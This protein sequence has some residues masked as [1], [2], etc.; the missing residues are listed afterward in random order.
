M[1]QKTLISRYTPFYF[2]ILTLNGRVP[3][4]AASLC[5]M[6]LLYGAGTLVALGTGALMEAMHLHLFHGVIG[7]F[8]VGSFFLLNAFERTCDLATSLSYL[9]PGDD[10]AKFLSRNFFR[11][12]RSKWQI[13]V[14][15]ACAL[16]S[17]AWFQF[18]VG[19]LIP[20]MS[21]FL[22]YARIIAMIC[23]FFLFPG[24]WL[25]ATSACFVVAMS[26][27]CSS[28]L[29]PVL[30]GATPSLEKLAAWIGT[31]AIYFTVEGIFFIIV[32]SIPHYPKEYPFSAATLGIL[33]VA[34]VLF[35]LYLIYP[36]YTLYRMIRNE[37]YRQMD[38]VGREMTKL[39]EQ[40]LKKITPSA[41]TQFGQLLQLMRQSPRY[42]SFYGGV[43]RSI[44][45]MLLWLPFLIIRPQ[46]IL[47]A[48]IGALKKLFQLP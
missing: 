28:R 25:A 5:W 4:L 22:L 31:M 44:V 2:R 19:K 34:I 20:H 36:Q 3:S 38:L 35:M 46:E 40:T 29:F 8:G 45:A 11:M 21:G 41:Y 9:C 30:P 39:E 18:L 17:L 6:S 47:S 10:G 24:V 15:A 33:T 26:R 37:R 14:C 16:G 32:A 13:F 48:V 27:R 42:P 1:L 12:Y 43:V 7:L 23:M